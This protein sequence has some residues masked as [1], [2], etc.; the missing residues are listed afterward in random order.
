[1]GEGN[2]ESN[3][4]TSLRQAGTARYMAREF[5]DYNLEDVTYTKASDMWAFGMTCVA[6]SVLSKE[7]WGNERYNIC[8]M[9]IFTARHPFSHITEE[10]RLGKL[11]LNGDMPLK[12]DSDECGPNVW[13]FVQRCW[14]TDLTARPSATD[15][16]IVF[17]QQ[18][19]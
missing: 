1:M 14:A 13:D 9:Q 7:F 17:R 5:F 3:F 8:C 16:M 12:P 4:S 10:R 19:A 6:V 15:A 11:I 18:V 2:N